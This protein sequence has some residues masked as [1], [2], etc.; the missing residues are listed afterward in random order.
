[1]KMALLL[2][3]LV[4][5]LGCQQPSVRRGTQPVAVV[6]TA[7]VAEDLQGL[8]DFSSRFQSYEREGQLALCT[9]MRAAYEEVPN[10][11]T[12]WY[13]ATAIS[14]VEGCG[15]PEEAVGWIQ[16]M[17]NQRF[18]SD[19]V[20]WVAHYQIRLLQF[21]QQQQ[22]KL[23]KA[24]AGEKRLQRRLSQVDKVNNTLEKQ[25]RDLKRIET[26]INRRLDE[27]QESN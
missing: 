19:E 25:L 6:A 1:M 21:Q 9:E 15:D 17:L 13:L 10:R 20:S 2:A 26:S 14:Q 27:K 18:V 11:W 7:S 24:L 12:G 3:V 22:A 4:L 23:A 16:A 5:L 8:I